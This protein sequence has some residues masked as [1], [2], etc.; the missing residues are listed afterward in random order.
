MRERIKN[1]LSLYALINMAAAL[2][3]SIMGDGWHHHYF[4]F[5]LFANCG[6]IGVGQYFTDK[7]ESKYWALEAALE[8]AM[9]TSMTLICSFLFGW[10]DLPSLWILFLLIVIV[11]SIAYS[12]DITRTKKD[13]DE[14]NQMIQ[15]RKI[16]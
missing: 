11:Y 14:I 1:M 3:Y 6:L 2:Q 7:Y 9:V 12:L 8:F 13:V 10:F 16:K 15:I 5:Q 4:A